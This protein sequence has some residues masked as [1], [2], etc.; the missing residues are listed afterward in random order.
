[1]RKTI[2]AITFVLLALSVTEPALAYVGPGAGL[3][4][5][6]ALWGLLLAV[7]AALGFLILWPVR[8][9]LK[10]GRATGQK[11][12]SRQPATVEAGM[13]TSRVSPE[14]ADRPD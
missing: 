9:L 3:S 10:R 11:A 5:L 4:L 12:E 13:A 1:M 14:R 8:R 7:L 6:G 2:T